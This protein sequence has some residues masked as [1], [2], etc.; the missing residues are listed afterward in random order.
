MLATSSNV[1]AVDLALFALR[2]S[3][4]F[5]I[6]AHGLNKF[7]GGGK[8]PGTA[9]WFESIGMRPGYPNAVAAA[10]TECGVGVL[11]V[12]GLLTPLA[13]AGLVALM[14][15]AIVTV[16][17]KNGFFIFRPGQ[18]IEYCLMTAVAAVVVATIGPGPWS[19]DHSWNLWNYQA[20]QGMLVAVLV[21][22][23]GATLQL[24]AVW[25]PPKT[26]G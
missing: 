5:M 8:L 25:R 13:S 26:E 16:H 20:L 9:R 17:R 7:F 3:L 23:G 2:A 10:T 12:A 19:L 24:V 1:H 21:G 22:V 11:L 15:V 4:G 6:L 18:G 14:T